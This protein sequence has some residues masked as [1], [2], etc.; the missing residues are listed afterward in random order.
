ME[1]RFLDCAMTRRDRLRHVP[2]RKAS[3]AR[4][5]AVRARA[6]LEGGCGADAHCVPCIGSQLPSRFTRF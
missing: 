6:C 3:A 2:C 4:N 5:M 1:P